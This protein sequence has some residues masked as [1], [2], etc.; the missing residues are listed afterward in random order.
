MK[1]REF[2]EIVNEVREL[3]KVLLMKSECITSFVFAFGQKNHIIEIPFK[4]SEEKR[5]VVDE[6]QSFILKHYI[7][8]YLSLYSYEN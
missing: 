5:I 6:L 1:Y 7:Y 8:L 2:K 4:N 3:S